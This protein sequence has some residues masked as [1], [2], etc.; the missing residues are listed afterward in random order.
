MRHGNFM[1]TSALALPLVLGGCGTGMFQFTREW[2]LFGGDDANFTGGASIIKDYDK[3]E[4]VETADIFKDLNV[5]LPPDSSISSA[6]VIF[7]TGAATSLTTND[8]ISMKSSMMRRDAA[9]D[10]ILRASE[11]RCGYYE[12]YL[13]RVQSDS[14][15]GF[16]ALATVLGGAGAI[17][18]NLSDARALAGAAG[19]SSGVGAEV[20]KEL[21]SNLASTVIIPGIE[22]RRSDLL[23]K[24]V[25][26]RCYAVDQYTAGMAIAD[27][28]AYHNACSLDT[29]IAEAGLAM[30]EASSPGLAGLANMGAA[31][32]MIANI[33]NTL[34][35]IAKNTKTLADAADKP[36]APIPPPAPTPVTFTNGA[37]P[38]TGTDITDCSSINPNLWEALKAPKPPAAAAKP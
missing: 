29:G 32:T 24:M 17:V 37:H 38:N 27:A 2:S 34:V 5:V 11:S 19:I 15:L 18:T 12:R 26:N 35:S 30:K 22:K 25:H 31:L 36:G 3:L 8:K 23:N 21:F 7:Q 1:F 33:Q 10:R 4:K 20:Q 13:R 16:G 28:I 6:L 9:Q 14:A